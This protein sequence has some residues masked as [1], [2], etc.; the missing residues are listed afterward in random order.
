MD[1]S[2]PSRPHSVGKEVMARQNFL[3]GETTVRACPPCFSE[4]GKRTTLLGLVLPRLVR[5]GNFDAFEVAE[6]PC[7]T[8]G[9]FQAA[10][11]SPIL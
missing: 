2:V 3:P 11:L 8:S 7:D 5:P 1:E 10:D 4:G 6:R 9:G